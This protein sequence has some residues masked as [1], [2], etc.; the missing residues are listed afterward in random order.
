MLHDYSDK[1]T[2]KV[3][4]RERRKDGTEKRIF[5]NKKLQL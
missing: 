4:N 5:K 3:I 1:F 2:A